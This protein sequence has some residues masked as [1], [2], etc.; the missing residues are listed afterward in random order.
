LIGNTESTEVLNMETALPDDD[1][2]EDLNPPTVNYE[3]GQDEELNIQQPF[4]ED[5][6]ATSL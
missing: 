4:V 5:Q 1:G 6:P 3:Y 2:V